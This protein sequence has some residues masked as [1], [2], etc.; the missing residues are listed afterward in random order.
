MIAT[1]YHGESE[2]LFYI[3]DENVPPEEQPAVVATVSTQ[4]PSVRT[5]TLEQIKQE[6]EALHLFEWTDAYRQNPALR[7]Q[8]QERL[9]VLHR[10][11]EQLHYNITP[12]VPDDARRERYEQMTRDDIMRKFPN[13]VAHLICESLGYATPTHA[14]YILQ[15]AIVGDPDYCEWID[16]CW[17]NDPTGPV[18][19]AIRGRHHHRGYM[20]HYPNARALVQHYLDEN[21][22]P[23]FASWF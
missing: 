6:M 3:V 2:T 13:V 19:A 20:A 23:V 17:R 4:P 22:E 11:H 15:R 9:N 1:T 16:A 12:L 8:T 21:R 18:R 14:A 10:R 5:M 7:K